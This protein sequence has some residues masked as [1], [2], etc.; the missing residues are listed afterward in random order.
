MIQPMS[1]QLLLPLWMACQQDWED[2]WSIPSTAWQYPQVK[3]TAPCLRQCWRITASPFW[4]FLRAQDAAHLAWLRSSTSQPGL[5]GHLLQHDG[6]PY[7]QCLQSLLPSQWI[8][9][10]NRCWSVSPSLHLSV[11]WSDHKE[12][13]RPPTWCVLFPRALKSN[14]NTSFR[15]RSGRTFLPITSLQVSLSLPMWALK[16]LSRTME[17]QVVAISSTSP[18]TSRKGGY[19]AL[20]FRSQAKTTVTCLQPKGAEATH[21]FIFRIL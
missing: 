20:L 14:N 5:V 9:L 8:Q 18:R 11:I 7:F 15:F 13:H 1:P 19:P 10:S 2:P 12:D 3:S 21:S 4:E 6:I 17:S 16:S